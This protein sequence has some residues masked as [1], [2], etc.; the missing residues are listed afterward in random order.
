MTVFVVELDGRV[1]LLHWTRL[2]DVVRVFAELRLF[3]D[4]AQLLRIVVTLGCVGD[5][6]GQEILDTV[7]D[8]VALV[9]RAVFVEG[10]FRLLTNG[11]L[12]NVGG[13]A[14][15]NQEYFAGGRPLEWL[16]P[17]LQFILF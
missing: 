10:R 4:P 15:V 12:I 6:D 16:A 3:V 1:G 11:L 17:C 9:L 5:I 2:A 14:G 13:P 8:V 7:K